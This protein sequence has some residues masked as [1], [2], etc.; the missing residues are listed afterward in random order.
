MKNPL[1]FVSVNVAVRNGERTIRDCLTS[2]INM[3]Y[4]SDRREIL[5]VDNG[6]SDRT[7]EII[8]TFPVTYLWEERRG[9]PF[10]RNKGVEASQGKILAFTDADC[11]VSRKWLKELVKGFNG[12][13][14]GVVVGEVFTFPCTSPAQRYMASHKP[15]WQTRSLS[16]G[17]TPWFSLI[18]TAIRKEVFQQV[19]RFDPRFAG[20]ACTDTDF[21][22]RFF[23]ANTFQ[24]VRS[25]KA[26]AFHQHR[27]N[28]T[29]LFVQYWGY[30]K[31][32]SI[33][34]R[35]YPHKVNWDWRRECNAYRDLLRLLVVCGRAWVGSGTNGRNSDAAVYQR[36]EFVRKLAERLGFTWGRVRGV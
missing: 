20:V 30:G 17:G 31:G 35:K 4:P 10:A 2:L 25:I 33:L 8:K 3:D 21:S 14:V 18:N 6:S 34:C 22:W 19:G 15:F 13:R 23:D 32:Q 27:L 9:L 1:P 7:A 28:S 5:V 26:A 11:V 12:D 16:H 36:L 24:L 29:G